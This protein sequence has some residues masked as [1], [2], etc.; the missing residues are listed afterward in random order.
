[1]PGVKTYVLSLSGFGWHLP[2]LS[3]KFP[4]EHRLRLLLAGP[5][6]LFFAFSTFFV[7]LSFF[8]FFRFFVP[9]FLV[10]PSL[11]IR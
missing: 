10:V 7:L 1:M 5:F 8:H 6:Q 11:F 3:Q 4:A 9:S 2:G